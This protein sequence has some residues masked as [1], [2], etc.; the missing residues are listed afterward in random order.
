LREQ[1]YGLLDVLSST[2]RLSGVE[3]ARVRPPIA[4]LV[5][6]IDHAQSLMSH[7]SSVRLLLLRRAEQLRNAETHS[8][9]EQARLRVAKRLEADAAPY[10]LSPG[11]QPLNLELPTVSADPAAFPWLR[12]RLNV[13]IYEAHRMGEA[14]RPALAL[15]RE[16]SASEFPSAPALR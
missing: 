12:R 13:T 9:L 7:L 11:A 8:T 1:A 5:S 15:M 2:V 10:S 14:G 6:F 3:P 16:G 4:L